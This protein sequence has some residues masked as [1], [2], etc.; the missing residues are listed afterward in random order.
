[1]RIP[2]LRAA[3]MAYL[4]SWVCARRPLL[5]RSRPSCGERKKFCMSIIT[6]ADFGGEIVMVAVV[7]V[8]RVRRGKMGV[9]V[10]VGG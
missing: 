10:G 3:G 7:V 8:V 2:A 9:E 6:R 4:R 1:M 5:S